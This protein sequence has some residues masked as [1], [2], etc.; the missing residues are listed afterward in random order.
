MGHM[1]TTKD[2]AQKKDG[3]TD[4][5]VPKG[6]PAFAQS[7]QNVKE[8]ANIPGLTPPEP[9]HSLMGDLSAQGWRFREFV[10]FD[11]QK[12]LPAFLIA[13]HRKNPY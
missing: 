9:Y 8:L 4:Q 7:G 13:Y 10:V 11:K 3:K 2:S 6:N 1:V 12:I 5:Y